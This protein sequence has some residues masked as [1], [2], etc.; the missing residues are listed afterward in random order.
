[1]K[2]IFFKYS[3]FAILFS[4]VANS[5]AAQNPVSEKIAFTIS[6]T[7][8]SYDYYDPIQINFNVRNLSDQEINVH[9]PSVMDKSIQLAL[10]RD[11][12]LIEQNV[13]WM[14]AG[15]ED[16]IING[17]QEFSTS[18]DLFDLYSYL[19]K[20][21][22][23]KLKALY[24]LNDEVVIASNEI[25]LQLNPLPAE[26]YAALEAAAKVEQGGE[27][28]AIAEMAN[29]FLTQYPNSI[30]SNQV[31]LLLASAYTKMGQEVNS[32]P[33][34]ESIG[35]DERTPARERDEANLKLA[36]IYKENNKIDKALKVLERIDGRYAKQLR[37]NWKSLQDN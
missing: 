34:F 2:V 10:F 32:I 11:G 14:S 28:W 5:L 30:F 16:V 26:K 33:I 7:A 29:E 1:M 23:F 24:H 35:V 21:G 22:Q 8:G 19:L 37:T 3:L 9:A 13:T 36:Y 20:G 27:D 31:K 12:E 6:S 4:L 17:R 18:Y 15:M 25:S